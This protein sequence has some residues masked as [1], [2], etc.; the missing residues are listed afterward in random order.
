M[1]VREQQTRNRG[2]AQ[3]ARTPDVGN[4]ARLMMM[5]QEKGHGKRNPSP[6][7]QMVRFGD[8][9]GYHYRSISPEQHLSGMHPNIWRNLS[10]ANGY[11]LGWG[12]IMSFTSG[13]GNFTFQNGISPAGP[14]VGGG[15]QGDQIVTRGVSSC[16]IIAV[17]LNNQHVMAHLDAHDLTPANLVFITT[18]VPP[19][20]LAAGQPEIF[21][22]LHNLPGS[23]PAHFARELIEMYYPGIPHAAG[24]PAAGAN[25]QNYLTNGVPAGHHIRFIDRTVNGNDMFTH[26]EIGMAINAAGQTEIF[27]R[28]RGA[29]PSPGR[30][31]I[32]ISESRFRESATAPQAQFDDLGRIGRHRQALAE[33]YR[34][35]YNFFH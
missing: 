21:I 31:H 32:S 25:L 6:T 11:H 18:Q 3:S 33:R 4:S 23:R 30:N 7:I 24:P 13:G 8:D 10:N 35:I 15:I 34:R 28:L 26:P 22:S 14:I 19:G 27:G 9:F 5:E 17:S 12:S 20:P 2:R 1:E 29:A 16:T